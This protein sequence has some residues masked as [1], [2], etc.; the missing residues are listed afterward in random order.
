MQAKNKSYKETCW[1]KPG[2]S[3]ITQHSV[4]Y[5]SQPDSGNG[6]DYQ[7]R[8]FSLHFLRGGDDYEDEAILL[9]K[10]AQALQRISIDITREA[11]SFWLRFK[12]SLVAVNPLSFP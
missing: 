10:A 7:K 12:P 9:H 6:S 2:K 1:I 5:G 8:V 3:H 11:G 4:S